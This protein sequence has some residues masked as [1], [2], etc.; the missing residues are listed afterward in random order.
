M[1]DLPGATPRFAGSSTSGGLSAESRVGS[2]AA[3]QAILAFLTA[4][5]RARPR[6]TADRVFGAPILT[7]ESQPLYQQVLAQRAV[8]EELARLRDEWVVLHSLPIDSLH[9][10]IDHVLIGPP[11]IFSLT[12]LHLAGKTLSALEGGVQVSGQREN[13]LRDAEFDVGRVERRL[14]AASGR[15]V[16]VI[17]IIVVVSGRLAELRGLPRD[18]EVVPVGEL[19]DRLASRAAQL[20]REC[21]ERIAEVAVLPT[22]WM[23]LVSRIAGSQDAVTEFDAIRRDVDRATSIHRLWLV[24]V[25]AGVLGVLGFATWGVILQTWIP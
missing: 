11:G 16:H 12:S 8:A 18:I 6:R 21:V 20:D 17:G 15:P 22:T 3:R 4:H 2:V 5:A 9:G 14:A 13:H 19:V 1:A 25:S 23:P 24:A 10:D 7:D